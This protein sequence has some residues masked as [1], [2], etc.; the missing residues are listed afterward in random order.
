MESRIA[1]YCPFLEAL[2]KGKKERHLQPLLSK[3]QAQ[4]LAIEEEL[5]TQPLP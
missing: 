1:S 5:A 4:L 3:A 2:A